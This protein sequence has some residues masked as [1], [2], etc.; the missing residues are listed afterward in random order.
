MDVIV[1]TG[2]FSLTRF[3]RILT[4]G[5]FGK[6]KRGCFQKVF[7]VW[8]HS[9][10]SEKS[11]SL[12][13]VKKSRLVRIIF[14]ANWTKFIED[15]QSVIGLKSRPCG[16]GQSLGRPIVQSFSHFFGRPKK[17]CPVSG[18]FWSVSGNF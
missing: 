16:F 1:N 10:K 8:S 4:H 17:N 18:N 9:Q 2:T 5:Y 6:Y 14:F 7:S 3:F 13:N 15:S 12:S 11:L